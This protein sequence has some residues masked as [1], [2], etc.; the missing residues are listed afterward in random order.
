MRSNSSALRRATEKQSTSDDAVFFNFCCTILTVITLGIFVSSIYGVADAYDATS[1]KKA[2]EIE[3][4]I[5]D[6][7]GT[8]SDEFIKD[9]NFGL[10]KVDGIEEVESIEQIKGSG[11][12]LASS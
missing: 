2:Q 10:Y 9:F 7:Q 11:E 1:S 12:L 5:E 3:L 8:E 4:K 6:W